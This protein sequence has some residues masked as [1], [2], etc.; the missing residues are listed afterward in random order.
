MDAVTQSIQNKMRERKFTLYA[1]NPDYT[2]LSFHHQFDLNNL[3]TLSGIFC[4]INLKGKDLT[5][6]FSYAIPKS[7]FELKSTDFGSLF[8]DEHFN[9]FFTKFIQVWEKVSDYYEYNKCYD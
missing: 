8:D 2:W 4:D 6:K 9:K 5:F 1:H 3:M 7:L